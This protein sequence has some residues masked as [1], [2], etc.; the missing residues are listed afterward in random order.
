MQPLMDMWKT[1]NTIE[2]LEKAG[3][4]AIIMVLEKEV[5]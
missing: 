2:V 5:I 3:T 1:T 4:S